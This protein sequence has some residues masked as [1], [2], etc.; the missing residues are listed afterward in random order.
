MIKKRVTDIFIFVLFASVLVACGKEATKVNLKDTGFIVTKAGMYDS[1]DTGAVIVAKDK[2][3][4]TLTFYNARVGRNYTLNYDGTS[5]LYDKYGSSLSMEQVEPGAIVDINFLKTKKLLNSLT[6]SSDAWSYDE[7]TDF[8]IDEENCTIA[9][10]SG[11]FKFDDALLVTHE[12]KK[13]ELMDINSVDTITVRGIDKVAKSINIDKGHGYIRLSNEDYFVGGWIEVGSKIIKT[14]G[15]NMLLAVPEGTYDVLVSNKGVESTLPVSVVINEE[16]ELDLG[17]IETEEIKTYG[18]L[19]VV[20]TPENAEVYIDGTLKDTDY[21]ITVEY[22]IHQLIARAGGY[23][24]LTQYIKVGQESATLDVTLEKESEI[25]DSA[26]HYVTPTPVPTVPIITEAVTATTTT[27][28]NNSSSNLVSG[29]KVTIESPRDA[30]VYLDGNYIG[31]APISF[32]KTTGSHEVI[33]R[34]E[35]YITRS[36]TISIDSSNRDENFSFSD[37]EE[38]E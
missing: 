3:A 18:T 6:M 13:A 1:A 22:G 37:L 8:V 20:T 32:A 5:K 19:V 25:S 14:V 21:P 15:E 30:E 31:I 29:Y 24:T 36:Y 38:N 16:T 9:T 10:G 4:K 34:K 7:I 2:E 12:G 35:G 27:G 28:N 33:L 26:G 17:E 11:V 23:E